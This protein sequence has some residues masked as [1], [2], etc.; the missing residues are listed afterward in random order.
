VDHEKGNEQSV[1][2][3]TFVDEE[4]GNEQMSEEIAILAP[5]SCCRK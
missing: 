2:Q 3:V 4:I 5:P 1:E